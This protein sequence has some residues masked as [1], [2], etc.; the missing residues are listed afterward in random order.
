MSSGN[1]IQVGISIIGKDNIMIII[2]KILFLLREK[3]GIL[4]SFIDKEISKVL[5]KSN[6]IK[7]MIN[8]VLSSPFKSNLFRVI[9]STINRHIR[10]FIRADILLS[11]S[12][13]AESSGGKSSIKKRILSKSFNMNHIIM[14]ENAEISI[15]HL[16][17]K[18]FRDLGIKSASISGIPFIVLA[19]TMTSDAISGQDIESLG[20]HT[21]DSLES[22]TGTPERI[23]MAVLIGLHDVLDNEI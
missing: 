15:S 7:S 10:A 13:I 21:S 23:I 3:I 20:D 6:G 2:D 22:H 12:I 11:F 1:E 8:R 18:V 5:L 19:K 4:S 16:I 9:L 14:N 17:N